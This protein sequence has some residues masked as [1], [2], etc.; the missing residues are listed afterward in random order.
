MKRA[1]TFLLVFFVGILFSQQSSAQKSWLEKANDNHIL[2]SKDKEKAFKEA[3]IIEKEAFAS[4]AQEAELTAIDTQCVYYLRKNDF[5][6]VKNKALQLYA[7]AQ[8]YNNLPYQT[9]AKIWLSEFYRFNQ[10]YDRAFS[11]LESGS[12]IINKANAQDSLVI[13]TKSNLYISYCNYY[14]VKNDDKNLLKY[15]RLS[16]KEHQKNPNQQYRQELEFLDLSNLATVY[17]KI[18]ADSAKYYAELSM[19]KDVGKDRNVRFNNLMMLGSVDFDRKNFQSA[20]QYFQKAEKESGSKNNIDVQELYDKLSKTY[21][22]LQDFENQKKY[23][24]KRDSLKLTMTEDQNKNLHSLLNEKKEEGISG[25]IFIVA[26]L[27]VAAI[28]A[29]FYFLRK[30]KVEEKNEIVSSTEN[31]EYSA[32]DYTT[33]LEMLK[34]N[35]PAFMSFFSKLYPDFNNT[36]LKVNPK[37]VATEIEFCALLKLKIATKDIARYKYITTKTVQNKKYLIRKKLNIPQEVDI[38]QWFDVL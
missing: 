25:Y 3:Q 36:L 7:K 8:Q 26:A 38:Y 31:T 18:N 20:L 12:E 1:I 11:E 4:G 9:N 6:N 17:Y 34:N 33:L 22:A 19:S 28:F 23:E 10:L 5:E 35:D 14:S 27:V 16:M 15:I 13:N 30:K 24:I 21:G 2:L 29:L 32:Q 37:L